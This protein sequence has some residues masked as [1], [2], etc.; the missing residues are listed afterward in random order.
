MSTIFDQIRDTKNYN[1]NNSNNWF[2]HH[3]T[4]KFGGLGPQ[5]FLGDN[6]QNQSRM[7]RPGQ[8]VFFGYS[9]KYKEELPYYDKFP[10]LLP[11]HVDKEHFMGLNLH[12]M[13]PKYRVMILDKL[14]DIA[15]GKMTTDR[16]KLQM[17]WNLLKSLAQHKL[18][19]FS[20]KQYLWGHVRTNFVV[21]PTEDWVSAVFLPLARFEKLDQ[22][23][24]WR[25]S[26]R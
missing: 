23:S 19:Q 8:L 20:V 13:Y 4:T 9:P 2:R 10:L 1:P 16:L 18:V 15:G 26:T 24:V 17:S 25:R 14:L 7:I 22:N 6:I 21:V 3:V 12:Y 11:F 5:K